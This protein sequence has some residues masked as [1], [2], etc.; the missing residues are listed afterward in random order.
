ML[1][2]SVPTTSARGTPYSVALSPDGRLLAVG[3]LLGNIVSLWDMATGALRRTI[4][5]GGAGALALDFSGDGRTLAMSGFEPVASLW[6]VETGTRIG[7]ALDAGLRAA[8]VDLSPDGR[9]LLM[10]LANGEGAVWDVDPDSWAVRAC[11]VA[12]R[13]L[14]R[15]EWEAYL[16]ADRTNRLYGLAGG[17]AQRRSDH[18]KRVR[19]R[20][21]ASPPGRRPRRTST[22]GA[23]ALRAISRRARAQPLAR[24]AVRE[25]DDDQRGAARPPR[26]CPP[27]PG[28][29]STGSAVIPSPRCS[30]SEAWPSS[31]LASR[32]PLLGSVRV[33]MSCSGDPGRGGEPGAELDRRPVVLVA[34]EGHHHG[35][36]AGAPRRCAPAT[37][38]TSHGDRASSAARSSVGRL[39][40]AAPRARRA[41]AAPRPP[42]AASRTA[43]APASADVKAATARD[44][45]RCA[46]AARTPFRRAARAASCPSSCTSAAIT[47][48]WPPRAARSD[49]SATSGSSVASSRGQDEDRSRRC[50]APAGGRPS[51]AASWRE[52]RAARGRCSSGPGSRPISST[53][54]PRAAR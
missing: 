42:R 23:A 46:A 11:A 33:P 36:L 27:S 54:L 4:D 9:R 26:R 5:N 39:R 21:G 24:E 7:P 40:R 49:A 38:A 53:S 41:A 28:S 47:S 17:L 44:T 6:D 50:G 37:S 43:S 32:R 20:G 13:T 30:A 12:N 52:D 51:G 48:S 25:P 8:M 29:T 16:R 22:T 31:R 19:A 18:V 10:T 3:E 2:W 45:P 15:E 35:L 14:T 1:G 34:A